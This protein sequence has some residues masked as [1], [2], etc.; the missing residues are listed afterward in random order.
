MIK[1]ERIIDKLYRASFEHDTCQASRDGINMCDRPAI[2]A[3]CNDK[4]YSGI[5]QKVDDN[6]IFPLCHECHMDQHAN[7]GSDWWLANILKPQM[8]RRY[9]GWKR[10]MRK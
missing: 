2:G 3:H 7:P 10:S 8:R 1:K 5:A 6:L 4:E 9:K